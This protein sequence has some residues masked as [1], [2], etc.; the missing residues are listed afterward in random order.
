[1]LAYLANVFQYLNDQNFRYRKKRV[2][3]VTAC[4]SL[5]AFRQTLLLWSRCIKQKNFPDSSVLGK[6]IL[7]YNNWDLEENVKA[8]LGQHLE[9]LRELLTDIS[10]QEIWKNQKFESPTPLSS[11]WRKWEM[12]MKILAI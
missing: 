10:L 3:I 4:D 9:G 7:K 6:V 2:N 5:H 1:M 12:R 11:N 8:E